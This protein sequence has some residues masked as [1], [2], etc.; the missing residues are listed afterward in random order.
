MPEA[1]SKWRPVDRL[2]GLGVVDKIALAYIALY[3]LIGISTISSFPL[4]FVDEPWL[5]EPSYNFIKNGS[6]RMM[7]FPNYG[8][9]TTHIGTIFMMLNVAVIWALGFNVF[10]VRLLPFIFFIG[11]LSV[12]YLLLR[13]LFDGKLA[14][15]VMVLASIHPFT[16]NASRLLRAESFVILFLLLGIHTMRLNEEASRKRVFLAGLVFSLSLLN[17]LAGLLSIFAGLV[18]ITMYYP[19]FSKEGRI[20]FFYYMLGAAP[21]L[22]IF[23]INLYSNFPFYKAMGS[24][25]GLFS[26]D[27]STMLKAYAA[28]LINGYD[29]PLL[30]GIPIAAF[31]GVLTF[32]SFRRMP[33]GWKKPY[34]GLA[35]VFISIN[36]F[37]FALSHYTRMYLVYL[38]IPGLFALLIPVYHLDRG[39]R[40]FIALSL[41]LGSFFLYQDFLWIDYFRK[42]NYAGYE[43]RL[44]E[45]IPAGSK[46]IGKINFRLSF[47]DCDYYAAEDLSKFIKKGL[48]K[49]EDYLKK[50]D[51]DYIV[52][53]YAWDYQSSIG[54]TDGHGTPH[55]ET[56]EFLNNK[57][58]LVS[59]IRESYYSNRFGPANAS[60][61]LIPYFNLIELGRRNRPDATYWT[62][63]YKIKKK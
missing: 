41:A 54:N 63:I 45:A 4:V 58:E 39:R 59:E 52:Y 47:A 51:I 27:L 16:V 25:D 35:S 56:L 21:A 1:H 34:I 10:A 18:I 48:G 24:S 50:Y 22:L 28:Y 14:L 12:I 29:M 7:S 57:A 20:K 55:E 6:M 43:R 13:R 60:H 31:I 3:L 40:I 37:I 11:S 5:A 15:A 53:D 26:K 46:V 32:I 30:Y 17:H 19:P 2:R 49:F 44:R 62:R 38:L 8:N 9:E 42:A 23:C 61:V 36:I 33:Q